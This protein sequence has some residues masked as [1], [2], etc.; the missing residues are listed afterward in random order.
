MVE[1]N[2]KHTE[3]GLIPHDWEVKTLGD[4]IEYIR[5]GLN[6]RIHFKLNTTDAYGYYITVR[7]LNGMDIVIDEQTDRINHQA[8]LRIN[9]RSKLK[10]GDVL[11]S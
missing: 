11:F 9:E 1:T 7:E 6:P 10:I 5:T 8:V 3:I 2:F 4:C